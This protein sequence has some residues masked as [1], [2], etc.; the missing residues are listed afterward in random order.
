MPASDERLK[1]LYDE[2]LLSGSRRFVVALG[3]RPSKGAASEDEP[4]TTT[5]WGFPEDESIAPVVVEEPRSRR[6]ASSS[7][8]DDEP[9]RVAEIGC[10]L[11]V[12][13][14]ADDR[15]TGLRTYEHAVQPVRVRIHRIIERPEGRL[16]ARVGVAVDREEDA[17]SEPLGLAPSLP[18]D[19][20]SRKT[21]RRSA[22]GAAEDDDEPGT[23]PGALL[24]GLLSRLDSLVHDAFALVPGD[25]LVGA[26]HHHKNRN[27]RNDGDDDDASARVGGA[28]TQASSSSSSKRGPA[29]RSA[30][31]IDALLRRRR[32]RLRLT[33]HR[34]SA[35]DDDEPSPL[36][37]GTLDE[38]RVM[39]EL[40]EIARLQKRLD[41]DVC[42]REEA[43]MALGAGPGAGVGSLWHL[44]NACWLLYLKAR[45]TTRARRVYSDIHDRLVDF[46]RDSGRLPPG[47]SGSSPGP[48]PSG[49]Q[50]SMPEQL[51]LSITELP[52]PLQ[53]DLL[54]LKQRVSDEIE[55]IVAQHKAAQTLLHADTHAARCVAFHKL[56]SAE[57]RRLAARAVLRDALESEALPFAASQHGL[58]SSSSSEESPNGT[59][60]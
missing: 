44:A 20:S 51:A 6:R 19:S 5:T 59:S 13:D 55:P 53:R 21:R 42:F 26:E 39:S 31:T 54:R 10:V 4:T 25:L 45:A 52:A 50:H 48:P 41:E 22:A 40:V 46:L 24:A 57:R 60:S 58:S 16:Y 17:T 32:R 38:R 28:H 36:S 56:L 35:E 3:E 2:I 30:A 43:V 15:A 49:P 7:F 33:R 12:T 23:T 29:L 1:Q 9:P 8:S 34:Q 14:V 11:Y 18:V 27:H 47:S 37:R